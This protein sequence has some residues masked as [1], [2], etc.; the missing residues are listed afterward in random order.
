MRRVESFTLRP[1]PEGIVTSRRAGFSSARGGAAA[2]D[3]GAEAALAAGGAAVAEGGGGVEGVAAAFSAGGVVDWVEGGGCEHAVKNAAVART[4]A[5]LIRMVVP[6]AGFYLLP[7]RKRALLPCEPPTPASIRRS[8]AGSRPDGPGS[9]RSASCR[10]PAS[11][12]AASACRPARGRPCR[13]PRA[14]RTPACAPRLRARDGDQLA[15]QHLEN[16]ASVDQRDR[17]PRRR[18]DLPVPVEE[19]HHDPV[20]RQSVT[21]P[22][23]PPVI[24]LSPP[25]IAFWTVLRASA[26]S[27]MSN[28]LSW[29]SFRALQPTRRPMTRNA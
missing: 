7:P 24:E 1:V 11:G 21:A 18:V 29:A 12:R 28:G 14:T 19:P 13:L 8:A 23:I 15:S 26:G 20:D 16:P 10:H 17:P 22:I 5:N 25:M 2:G 9:L 6:P 3:A 4:I 27:T